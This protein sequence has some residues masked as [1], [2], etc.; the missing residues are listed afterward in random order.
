M[1]F[2]ACSIRRTSGARLTILAEFMSAFDAMTRQE[3]PGF[4]SKLRRQDHKK[5]MEYA[6]ELLSFLRHTDRELDH[7]LYKQKW[8][9]DE[10]AQKH[11]LGTPRAL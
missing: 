1:S 11:G 6:D 2:L 3:R 5:K 8:L 4:F 7:L 9:D 10:E